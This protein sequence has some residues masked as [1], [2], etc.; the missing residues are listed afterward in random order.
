MSSAARD[1]GS[2]NAFEPADPKTKI[3]TQTSLDKEMDVIRHEDIAPNRNIMVVR[4]S[5]VIE[6]CIV[7]SL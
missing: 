5:A 4:A 1:G 2:Y 6:E 7:D 3:K